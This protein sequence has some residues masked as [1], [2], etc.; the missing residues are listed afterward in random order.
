[1]NFRK[2]TSDDDGRARV[3][4]GRV[5][6]AE[7]AGSCWLAEWALVSLVASMKAALRFLRN[8]APIYIVT[9][10]ERVGQWGIQ[11]FKGDEYQGH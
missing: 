1:M 9:C 2:W 10:L 5:A 3:T 4:S 11:Q 6:F 7:E 8:Q